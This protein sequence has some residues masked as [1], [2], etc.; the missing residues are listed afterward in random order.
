MILILFGPPGAGKG[1]QS[2]EITKEYGIPGISTG[3]LL[4]AEVEAKSELGLKARGFMDRGELVSD[5]LIIEMI[6]KR[7][8]QPDC[9]RWVI[10]DGVPRTVAQAESLDGLLS[11]VGRNLDAVISIEV[12]KESLVQRLSNRMSCSQ[13]K[14][15]YNR[16]SKPPRKEGICDR[17]GGALAQRSDDRPET[18]RNRLSVYEKQTAPVLEYYGR[19]GKT[20]AINGN[21]EPSDVTDQIRQAL[22]GVKA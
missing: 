16:I 17:C 20:V 19:K 6:R 1:T 12:D 14:E 21:G 10:L 4:R 18:I 2:V 22:A 8:G 7:I 5:S 13:C 3:D 9:R 15:G 11:E